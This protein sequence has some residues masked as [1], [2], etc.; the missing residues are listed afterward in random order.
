MV[1]LCLRRPTETVTFSIGEET[2]ARLTSVTN[3][4]LRSSRV[5]SQAGRHG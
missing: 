2:D 4:G 1:W 3:V 5:V